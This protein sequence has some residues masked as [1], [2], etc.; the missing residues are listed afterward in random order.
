MGKGPQ[1]SCPSHGDPSILAVQLTRSFPGNYFVTRQSCCLSDGFGFQKAVQGKFNSQA[2]NCSTDPSIF[3]LRYRLDFSCVPHA[4]LRNNDRGRETATSPKRES[5]TCPLLT[6]VC[7]ADH[8]DTVNG[9]ILT[10][11]REGERKGA[12]RCQVRVQGFPAGPRP[13][14]PG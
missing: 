10:Q 4:F 7:L 6:S 3:S 5:N 12:H 2:E 14:C 13:T 11:Q 9:V 1:R 8:K